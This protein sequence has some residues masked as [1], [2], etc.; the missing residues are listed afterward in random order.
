M[1]KLKLFLS[2]YK[3]IEAETDSRW[4]AFKLSMKVLFNI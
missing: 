1:K 2:N 4:L 3:T